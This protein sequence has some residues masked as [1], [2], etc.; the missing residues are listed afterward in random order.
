M[1]E[2]CRGARSA[3]SAGTGLRQNA[4]LYDPAGVGGTH[5]MYVL[6]PRRSSQAFTAGLPNDPTIAPTG[7]PVERLHQAP[8]NGGRHRRRVALGG[9]F[10]YVMKGPNEVSKEVED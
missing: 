5:V 7:L 4:G 2:L 6:Q 9:L 3:E 8:G 10:H 1:K